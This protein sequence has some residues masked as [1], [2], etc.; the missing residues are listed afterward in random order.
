MAKMIVLLPAAMLLAAAPTS[1][2]DAASPARVV[3]RYTVTWATP[4]PAGKSAGKSSGIPVG[5]PNPPTGP[6]VGN[7]DVTLLYSG[8]ATFVG[9]GRAKRSALDWQQWL[10]LSKNDMWGSDQQD[11][12]P[13]LSAGRV[14]INVAPLTSDTDAGSG[15]TAVPAATGLN[16]SVTMFP[17]NASIVHTLTDAT[18]SAM[19]AATTRV[20]ENNAVVTT[21]VCTTK[22]GGACPVELLLSDTNHNHYKVAQ[23]VGASPAGDLVWWRKENLHE[24]LNPAYV[25]SCDPHMPLQSVERRFTVDT[26]GALQMVNGSCLWAS[27]ASGMVTSGDCALPQGGWKWEGSASKGDIVQTASSKCLSATLKLGACGS[28]LWAQIPS[29]SANA[30]E[31]YLQTVA[32]SGCLVVVPDNNNN[33]LGVSLGIAD[34]TGTLVKGKTARVDATDASAGI[35]LSLS[36]KSGTEYTL[37]VGLQTLRDIGC[38]G[39]RPQWEKCMK[40]PEEAAVSLVSAMA[41]TSERAAAVA[42]A[43]AYWSGFWAASSV[44]LTSGLS[45]NESAPTYIVERWYY[46]AQYL[47]GTVA[48]DGKVTPALDGFVCV[49]PVPWSDQFT[50]DCAWASVYASPLSLRTNFAAC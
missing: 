6:F 50:L 9:A 48:R 34:P 21:L 4:G 17:G 39:I 1:G 3:D 32:K 15:N 5:Q 40:S 36:L 46:L 45:G 20:L 22:S 23:D 29:G 24:A 37:L 28:K 7:G 31:V 35:T 33:T 43:D 11:Y 25:G 44:D 41:R 16:G 18:G 30:S 8:N 38:A 13:H 27:N 14:G 19:V 49:E 47:L 42:T 26:D 10:Y 2:A 12:Y